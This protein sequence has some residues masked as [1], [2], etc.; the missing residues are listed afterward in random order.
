MSS[1]SHAQRCDTIWRQARLVCFD[2]GG[3]NIIDNGL[4]VAKNERILYAGEAQ[5]APHYQADS[6]IDC[7][8]RLITPALIDCHTHLIYAGSRADEFEQKLIG[9]SYLDI[10]NSGG[11][12]VSTMRATRLATQKQLVD[13]ALPRLD[14]L[15]AE[16]LAT[17]EIK[18]GYGLNLDDELKSLRA[19]LAL[20]DVRRVRILTTLLSAHA[21][22]PEFTGRSD[23][24]IE[25]I[26]HEIIPVVAR[27][28]LAQA[29]D[30]FCETI[31]FSPLQMARVFEAA[32]QHGL[33][34]K[35]HAEQLSNQGGA[36]LAARFKA[37]SADHLE[38]LSASGIEA[39][40]VA[41]TVATLLP[42]AYY[43]MRETKMPPIEALKK[44]DIPIAL[45][46][47]CN[48][49]TSPL[50][51]L[52]LTMNMAATLWRMPVA[53][54]LMGVTIN[55]AKA[56]GMGDEIGSLSVGKSC[57]LAIWDVTEPSELVYHMGL[58]R[59]HARVFKG[60][61]IPRLLKD[62]PC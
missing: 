7:Q 14:A 55:A 28:N 8:G 31:G 25:L 4:I 9:A 54:C 15:L 27:E 2:R 32:T 57:D 52:L 16:G 1:P 62:I 45:A 46:T 40:R 13:L 53:D 41:K 60:Q 44:A 18:S 21:L 19:G 10:A 5:Y 43:F 58:N 56:L 20:A 24:Y 3:L 23:D 6:D 48:P 61:T 36:E 26:C 39:M 37:L 11:G 35:L 59:L 22:P 42:G 12:I 51:S 33:R 17:I 29:V 30:G 49:G 47:D 50:T 38:Y 34:V